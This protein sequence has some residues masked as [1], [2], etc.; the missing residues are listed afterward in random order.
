MP[1]NAPNATSKKRL[2]PMILLVYTPDHLNIKQ[3][4]DEY[5]GTSQ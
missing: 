4:T 3:V 1:R 5:F 2:A